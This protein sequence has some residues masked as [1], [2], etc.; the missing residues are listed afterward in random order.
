MTITFLKTPAATSASVT[1]AESLWQAMAD[2]TDQNMALVNAWTST[3]RAWPVAWSSKLIGTFNP[4]LNSAWTEF[5]SA[6]WPPLSFPVP[7]G[8]R[9]M[10]LINSTTLDL[11]PA[12]INYLAVG[13]KMS[14]PGFSATL[15]P[16]WTELSCGTGRLAASRWATMP[17][18]ALVPGQTCTL[19]PAY[20]LTGTATPLNAHVYYGRVDVILLT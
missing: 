7:Q 15:L 17:T 5:D 11:N 4:P 16:E 18:T 9:G 1:D 13:A 8:V 20:R 10:W 2:T 3:G 6:V 19:T 12:K 14:G